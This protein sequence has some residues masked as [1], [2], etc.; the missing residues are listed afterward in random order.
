MKKIF[1]L[2]LTLMMLTLGSARSFASFE[3]RSDFP[4]VI[5]YHDVK[6]FA[7]N[8]FD[9]TLKD[10]VEQIKWLQRNNYE[11]L[12][13]DEFI[14]TIESGK[15][16]SSRA[17]LITF[18]DGYEDAGTYAA[19]ELRD[20]GMK[21]T[22]FINPNLIGEK[23][24]GYP[25]LDEAEVK[26]LAASEC[27][28]I[29]SHTINHVHLDQLSKEERVKE[30]AE[31]KRALEELIGKPVR[32]LAYP[33]GDY[34]QAVIDDTIETGYEVGFAVQDRGLFERDARWSI[35]RIYMG[36]ILC[37][38]KQKLFKE[39]VRNY[40]KMPPEAFEERWMPLNQ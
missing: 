34:D 25:Y 11:T 18:D 24:E 15:K 9:V 10:F 17:V 14:E 36:L 29:G 2:A 26:A 31:S 35:P 21:A 38:N 19:R 28:S 6:L 20:R 40:K 30:L 7:L 8:S 32:S 39:Y 22:F 16:F 27:F 3:E 37:G 1:L 13:M 23:L 12:S 33:Y 4:T 5:M